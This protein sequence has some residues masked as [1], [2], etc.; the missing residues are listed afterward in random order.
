MFSNHWIPKRP[1]SLRFNLLASLRRARLRPFEYRFSEFYSHVAQKDPETVLAT[2]ETS[3]DGLTPDEVKTRTEKYG[4]NEIVQEKRMEWHLQL[5]K[6]FKN[7]FILL[8]MAL[9]GISFFTD[10]VAGGI[11]VSVMVLVSVFLTFFQ[12][13]RSTKAAEKLRAMV[14]TTATAIRKQVIEPIDAVEAV[15]LR[16]KP[17]NLSAKNEVPISELVPGDIIQ[18]SAG[19]M[20]PADVR[21]ITSKDMFISQSTLTG[22]ALPVEKHFPKETENHRGILDQKNL[23]FMGSNVVS[24]TAIAAVLNTG[25]DTYFGSLAKNIVGQRVLTSFD[26]GIHRFTWLMI[27][28]MLVMVPLVFLINGLAKGDWLEAFMFAIAVAVGLTPEMLPMI[29]TVNLAKGALAMSKKRVI[30]K[31][32]TSIQNF[33]AMDVLCTD[34][35]GTLT[36]DK[37]ILEKYVDPHG[38]DSEDV[39]KYAYLNS[40]YQTGLKN[41]LDRA[42]LEHVEMKGSLR[43]DIDYRKIDE[44][45][46]DFSRRRMSVVV[47]EQ[48]K[49]HV[50]ICKGALEEILNVSARAEIDSKVFSITDSLSQSIQNVAHALNEDG[51]RVI[52][53]AYK[54]MPNAQT[55]YSVRDERDLILLGFIAFLDPP[56]ETAAQA[57]RALNQNG[58]TVKVLTGDNE[59]VT[60]KI[61]KEVGLSVER[62]LLGQEVEKMTEV[63][64]ADSTQEVHVFAKLTP[65]Q[66]Q[67]I[68]LAMHKKGHVVG[69]FGRWHQ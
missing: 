65:A 26:R 12:E 19:D 59:I 46:F 11:I 66:K 13:F 62:I 51:L 23:A 7:P 68:I 55:D 10:D 40:F 45:P 38:S 42:V 47:E 22:E 24:G 48:G 5:L 3:L 44:I 60:R 8:L 43:V 31:R 1:D 14:T 64:L 41:L 35:T 34:K 17:L 63:E 52:A 20:I 50:L 25:S 6:T 61:C 56:K 28:F 36:Q 69:F 4:T 49:R 37:V 39:L 33:G 9:A 58:I 2:L 32:L 15:G 53:V 54:E 30:V 16:A 21:L 57:I 29:V 18:L 27:R 67:R